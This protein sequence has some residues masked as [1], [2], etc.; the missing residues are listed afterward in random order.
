MSQNTVDPNDWKDHTQQEGDPPT[1]PLRPR[2]K[3][4]T[5]DRRMVFDSLTGKLREVTYRREMTPDE[6]EWVK[7]FHDQRSPTQ[8]S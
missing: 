3:W 4:T 2:P 5:V 7:T 6:I 8:G 1:G